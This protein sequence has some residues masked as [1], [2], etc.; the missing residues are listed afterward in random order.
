MKTNDLI[1]SKHLIARMD[2]RDLKKEWILR[3]IQAPDK[4]ES[5]NVDEMYFLK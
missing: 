1:F 2:Q 3:T 4:E 5:I